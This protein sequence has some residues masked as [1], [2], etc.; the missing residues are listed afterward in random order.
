MKSQ[1]D[2]VAY[3]AAATSWYGLFPVV[4][5]MS[6]GFGRLD[7]SLTTQGLLGLFL[8]TMVILPLIGLA[9]GFGASAVMRKSDI[10]PYPLAVA[11]A[12]IAD[13]CLIGWLFIL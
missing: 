7:P 4:V 9:C 8:G 12:L 6:F 11:L 3:V 5:L 10:S 13:F 2:D 1:P